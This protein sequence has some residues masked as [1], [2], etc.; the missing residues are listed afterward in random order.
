MKHFLIP[1]CVYLFFL[2]SC[3]SAADPQPATALK[4]QKYT[5]DSLINK[6]RKLIVMAKVRGQ[7]NIGAVPKD[8]AEVEVVYNIFKDKNG[9]IVYVSE[10]PKSPNDDWFIA[11]KSYFDENGNLFAFQRQNNFFNSEC[12]TGA[13]LE[14]LQRFYNDKFEVLDS[15]YTLT[16]SYKKDLTQAPCKFPYNFPYKI[17]KNVDEYRTGVKGL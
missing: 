4:D 3:S 5:I 14:N 17:Y 15:V 12:T 2:M 7:K 8:P 16:D 6:E 10:M 9:R 1:V 13:A 11:Y